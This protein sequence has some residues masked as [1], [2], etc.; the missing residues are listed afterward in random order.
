[1]VLGRMFEN[2]RYHERTVHH[3]TAQH[4]RLLPGCPGRA[5]GGA[6]HLMFELGDMKG[7]QGRERNPLH[8]E[9]RL[10][11]GGRWGCPTISARSRIA[12]RGQML[13]CLRVAICLA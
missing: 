8:A 11:E 7:A 2:V 3:L 6:P 9:F 12:L 5:F 10:R 13:A 4:C 1:V